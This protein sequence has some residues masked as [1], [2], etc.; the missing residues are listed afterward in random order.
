MTLDTYAAA[1]DW[2]RPLWGDVLIPYRLHQREFDE[3]G[4][5]EMTSAFRR[6]LEARATYTFVGLFKD[7]CYHPRLFAQSIPGA[8]GLRQ[9]CPDC[10]DTGFVTKFGEV[11]RFPM[12]AALHRLMSEPA[13]TANQPTPAQVVVLLSRHA[14]DLAGTALSLGYAYEMMEALGLLSLRKL[15]RRYAVRPIARVGWVSKS[16]A[17]RQAEA[18]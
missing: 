4:G 6:L 13:M 15:E 7:R 14:W 17:Q 2:I 18:M 8:F 1:V 9:A 12:A 11:Y 10:D 5:P 3:G 16:D